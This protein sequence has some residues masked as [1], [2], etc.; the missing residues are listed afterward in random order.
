MKIISQFS[1]VERDKAKLKETYDELEI[2]NNTLLNNFDHLNKKNAEMTA[3]VSIID[4]DHV[5]Y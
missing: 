3:T 2:S 4:S 5:F 1:R